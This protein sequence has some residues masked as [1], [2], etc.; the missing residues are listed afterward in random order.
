MMYLTGSALESKR[1]ENYSLYLPDMRMGASN[2]VFVGTKEQVCV[3]LT[4]S[5][6]SPA[7]KVLESHSNLCMSLLVEVNTFAAHT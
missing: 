4:P 7:F 5:K 3:Y 1:R 2:G 6:A